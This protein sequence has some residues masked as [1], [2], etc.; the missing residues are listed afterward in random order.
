MDKERVGA[1]IDAVYA[2]AMTILV[3]ELPIPDSGSQLN[4]YIGKIVFAA[5]DYGLTFILLFAFWYNQRRINDLVDKHSRVTL[6][7]NGLALMMIALMPFAASLLYQFGDVSSFLNHSEGDVFINLLFVGVC[8]S[9]DLSI[10]CSLWLVNRSR[11]YLA[12]NRAKIVKISRSRTIA[13][14]V[15]V[16]VMFLSIFLPGGDRRSLI[17]IPLVLIFE[18][19]VLKTWDFIRQLRRSNS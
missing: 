16:L 19:E 12:E 10:N 18:E 8:L 11:S 3:L 2:I 7:L 4:E 17:I 15:S 6:W 9:A 1:L 5:L 14:V 13:V